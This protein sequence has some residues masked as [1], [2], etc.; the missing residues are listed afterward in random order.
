MEKKKRKETFYA[1]VAKIREEMQQ[2][3]RDDELREVLVGTADVTLIKENED[4]SA[5]YSFNFPPEA[6]EALTR[7]GIM[8]AIQAGIEGTK[9]MHPDYLE[10]PVQTMDANIKRLAI[11]A[12]FIAWDEEEWKPEGIVFDWA[13]ADDESLV[14]FCHLVVR[15][16]ADIAYEVGLHRQTKHEI[17]RRFGLEVTDEN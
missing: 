17:L 2:E 3:E 16:C 4:G 5:V 14:N 7:L 13:G 10:P 8:T 6:M 9:K 11:E 1:D 15:E 12:G